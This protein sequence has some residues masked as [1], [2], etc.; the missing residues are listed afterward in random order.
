MI[1]IALVDTVERSLRADLH[2]AHRFVRSSIRTRTI[3]VVNLYERRSGQR[4][5]H[6]D[7]VSPEARGP[8]RRFIDSDVPEMA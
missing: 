8:K 2:V 3:S 4:Q 5:D 1:Y 6:L 7:R